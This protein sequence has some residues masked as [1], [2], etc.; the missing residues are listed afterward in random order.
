MMSMSSNMI[1]SALAATEAVIDATG[2][3]QYGRPIDYKIVNNEIR[4]AVSEGV[5]NITLMGVMGQRY[6]ATA[7]DKKINIS[8]NGTPGNN[9]GAFMD[10]PFIEVFGNAQDMTGNT[11]SSGEIIVH[12]NAWDVTGLSMRGGKIFVKGNT[13]TRVGIHM[14]EFGQM[15]P[16]IVIGG[17]AGDYLGEY[18]AGG[19]ILVLGEN[20]PKQISPVGL[21][22]GSGIHGGQIFIRGKVNAN[23]LGV[24]AKLETVNDDDLKLINE[25]IKE[26]ESW[27]GSSSSEGDFVKVV[28]FS[29][30]PFRGHFDSTL[31]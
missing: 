21:S 3:D 11:M 9:L 5:K 14:K 27:F 18:M 8:I 31:I 22:I 4:R 30:R 17:R 16:H 28:P 2:K 26:Y 6:I 13:G 12:G 7:V 24:G 29:S 19:V 23:Q 25:L 20:I 10:G 15:S 1:N